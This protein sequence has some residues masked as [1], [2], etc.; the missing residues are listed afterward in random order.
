[1]KVDDCYIIKGVR[2]ILVNGIKIKESNKIFIINLDSITMVCV[3]D[4]L[5]VFSFLNA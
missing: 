1:M 5:V 4:E 2:K 3:L